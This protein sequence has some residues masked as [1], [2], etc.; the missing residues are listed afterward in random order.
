[1]KK[2]LLAFMAMTISM[3]ANAQTFPMKR[4]AEG[5]K[6]LSSYKEERLKSLPYI[7]AF[8]ASDG[9][10]LKAADSE[11]FGI[12]IFAGYHY[13]EEQYHAPSFGLSGRYDAK[14]VSYRL[15]A[16]ATT[17]EYNDEAVKAGNRYW[18]YAADGAFHVNLFNRGYHVNVLSVYGTIGYLYGQHRYAVG[19][20]IDVNGDTIQKTVKHNG[21][22]VTYGGGLEYRRQFFATGNALSIRCGYRTLPNTFVN[23]TKVFG[24]LYAEIGFNFG[25][26]RS[27]VRN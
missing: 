14:K 19:E 15:S 3:I 18:S 25:C 6:S 9:T 26:K 27:R 1:M 22:G 21:S 2:F 20:E 17:R 11:G 16:S 12:E 24:T 7:Q 13:A 4:T 23:N 5:D 8:Q 10:I